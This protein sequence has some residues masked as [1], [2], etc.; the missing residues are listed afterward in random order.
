MQENW[1]SLLAYIVFSATLGIATSFITNKQL[2]LIENQ[3]KQLQRNERNLRELAARDSLTGL[4]NHG[5]MEEILI[6]ELEIARDL[7]QSLGIIMGD[8]DNFKKLNDTYG[9]EMGDLVLINVAEILKK[10]IRE[11]DVACRYGGDEFLLIMPNISLDDIRIRAEDIRQAVDEMELAQEDIEIDFLTFSLGIAAFPDN[12]S[13]SQELLR[14]VDS[15]LYIA[16][17]EG[18]NKVG[19]IT[20]P[21]SE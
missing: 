2:D 19:E 17:R 9:H 1:P 16:K 21:V 5:H 3:K 6:N 7:G 13:T 10:S 4:Y 20:E 8:L 18:R 12:G 11:T 14:A 15:A